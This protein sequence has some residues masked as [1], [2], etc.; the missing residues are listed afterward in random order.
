MAEATSLA[1]SALPL[2]FSSLGLESRIEAALRAKAR[3]S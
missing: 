3:T 2:R 1:L